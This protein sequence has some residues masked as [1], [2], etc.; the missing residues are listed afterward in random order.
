M[1]Y[2][3]H[4]LLLILVVYLFIIFISN[5]VYADETESEWVKVDDFRLYWGDSIKLNNHTIEA[6]EFSEPRKRY[7]NEDY[8]MIY[9]TDNSRQWN[10]ILSRNNTQMDNNI[11]LDERFKVNVTEIVTGFNITTPY[12]EFEFY[13]KEEDEEDIEF[14]MDSW[15]NSTIDFDAS[16]GHSVHLDERIYINV[17]V[18]NLKDIHFEDVKVISSYPDNFIYDPDKDIEWNFELKPNGKNTFSYS[19]KSLKPGEFTIPGFELRLT[20]LGVTYRKYTDDFDIEIYGPY[21]EIDKSLSSDSAEKGDILDVSVSI[22]NKGNRAANVKF[23]DEIPDFFKYVD[24]DTRINKVLQPSGEHSIQYSVEVI[25]SG[26]LVIPSAEVLATDTR[27]IEYLFIS[28]RIGLEVSNGD[29]PYIEDDNGEYGH[30]DVPDEP[31]VA[32]PDEAE[33]SGFLK[34]FIRIIKSRLNL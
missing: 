14:I 6:I 8:V 31:T 17:D 21:L 29:R 27:G 33:K 12:A 9:I 13:E 20:H 22:R 16:A 19:L 4:I 7:S 30:S 23:K 10:A 3:K 28:E 2:K 24:G 32:Y 25:E 15:I 18:N 26:S 34:E 1:T 5:P 11:V